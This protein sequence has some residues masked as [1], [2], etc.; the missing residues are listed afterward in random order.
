MA[1]NQAQKVFISF[2]YFSN[3]TRLLQYLISYSLES[4]MT[5]SPQNVRGLLLFFLYL[6]YAYTFSLSFLQSFSQYCVATIVFMILP[7]YL[8]LVCCGS[9]MHHFIVF[10]TYPP[11]VHLHPSIFLIIIFPS[12]LLRASCAFLIRT[13]DSKTYSAIGVSIVS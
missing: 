5:T 6:V 9:Y 10:P 1:T 8:F 4:A 2:P 11:I 13:H 12:H 3:L 7:A